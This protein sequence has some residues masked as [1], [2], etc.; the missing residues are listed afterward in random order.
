VIPEV[1]RS[2]LIGAGFADQLRRIA[3]LSACAGGGERDH[4]ERD[5]GKVFHQLLDS[6]KVFRVLTLNVGQK[7]YKLAGNIS[8]NVIISSAANLSPC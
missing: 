8:A 6:P 5:D 2:V 3:G 4:D 1:K 7:K